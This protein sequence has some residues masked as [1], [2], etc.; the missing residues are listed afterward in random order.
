M[1]VCILLCVVV[2]TAV[3]NCTCCVIIH[4]AFAMIH[5][6]FM[7]SIIAVRLYMLC[8]IIN[9]AVCNYTYCLCDDT[10]CFY[11]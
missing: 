6:A 7:V 4:I 5:I 10:Y 8:V 3:C 9:I 2:R 11:G 1:I